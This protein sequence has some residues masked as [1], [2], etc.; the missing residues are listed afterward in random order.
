MAAINGVL[1]LL[2]VCASTLAGVLYGASAKEGDVY[3]ACREQG[4]YVIDVPGQPLRGITCDGYTQD[5][6]KEDIENVLPT[7]EIQ[8]VWAIQ[9]ATWQMACAYITDETIDKYDLTECGA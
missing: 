5:E 3:L 4:Y 7:A 2:L 6:L 1:M 8:K 9:D